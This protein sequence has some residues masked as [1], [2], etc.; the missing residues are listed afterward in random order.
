MIHYVCIKHA[1]TSVR[2]L[3]VCEETN[4]LH[5]L[6]HSLHSIQLG[7]HLGLLRDRVSIR[8]N[9]R[10]ICTQIV[11]ICMPRPIDIPAPML[12]NNI[13]AE[14]WGLEARLGARTV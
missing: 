3:K 13:L 10:V 8:V 7:V 5:A 9:V 4:L 12:H 2:A 6:H 1:I 14:K 11:I